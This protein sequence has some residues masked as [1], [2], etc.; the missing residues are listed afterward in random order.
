MVTMLMMLEQLKTV[1]P[2]TESKP[3]MCEEEKKAFDAVTKAL[4]TYID[5]HNKCTM[6]KG[7]SRLD[8][9]DP[10]YML[11]ATYVNDA[12]EECSKNLKACKHMIENSKEVRETFDEICKEKHITIGELAYDAVMKRV[13]NGMFRNLLKG[14]FGK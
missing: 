7:S 4:D 5:V 12:V 8:L 11:G 2:P 9:K 14:V 3:L 10:Y 1:T 6:G 13:T